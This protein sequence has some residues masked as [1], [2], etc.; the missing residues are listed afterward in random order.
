MVVLIL[1]MNLALDELKLRFHS[2]RFSAP[3]IGLALWE[4]RLDANLTRQNA[5]T[6]GDAER[7]IHFPLVGAECG[8]LRN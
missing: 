3:P 8:G 4:N 5:L 7:H 6:V 1:G 2:S